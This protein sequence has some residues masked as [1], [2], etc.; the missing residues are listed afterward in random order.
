[1][2]LKTAYPNKDLEENVY[3]EEL[4]GHTSEEDSQSVRKLKESIC[5]LS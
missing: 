1:M 4:L 5:G 2:E 3:I